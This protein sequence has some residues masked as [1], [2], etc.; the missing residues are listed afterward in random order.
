MFDN[1]DPFGRFG[2]GCGGKENVLR[3]VAGADLDGSNT[4]P[5]QKS[6]LEYFVELFVYIIF[7][8]KFYKTVL[9][10]WNS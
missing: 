3:S 7:W 1:R 4:R 2:D 6:F 5:I 9:R 8:N 10:L